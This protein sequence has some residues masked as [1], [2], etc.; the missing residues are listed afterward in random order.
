MNGHGNGHGNTMEI[1][2]EIIMNG[3]GNY[4]EEDPPHLCSG[5]Q[6]VDKRSAADKL[7]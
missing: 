3:D 2:M 4:H 7:T 6:R 1:I 5:H